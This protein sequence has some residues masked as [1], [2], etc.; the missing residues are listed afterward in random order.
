MPQGGPKKRK[1]KKKK[2]KVLLE[3]EWDP[4]NH[5]GT[6]GQ[7]FNKAGNPESLHSTKLSFPVEA[8]LLLKPH[9]L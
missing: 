8:A 5:D 7:D 6:D 9:W 2:K 3:K 4:E 1:D